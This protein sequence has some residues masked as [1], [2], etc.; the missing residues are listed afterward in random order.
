VLEAAR[1][2]HADRVIER[3]PRRM[4]E[5]LGE[6]GV[7]LSSGE[8]QLLAFARALAGDPD[9]LIL[10]EATAHV[11]AATEALIRDGVRELLS[12]R[13]A[14]VI[15]HRLSTIRQADRI[16][17]L[18]KGEVREMGTHQELLAR[19]GIYERLY[20]LQLKTDP[21]AADRES[22]A[23]ASEVWTAEGPEEPQEPEE[24]EIDG[25]S[26]SLL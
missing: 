8:K 7:G 3:L 15:A 4:E 16:V 12:G 2:T 11:D 24:K 25:A 6:R 5:V 26:R 22:F 17:V 19:R 1:R 18:H 14:I 20:R 10:D 21:P 9:I 23:P 13:T